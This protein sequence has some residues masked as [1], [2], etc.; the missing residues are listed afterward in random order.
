MAK[1]TSIIP[2]TGRLG[3]MIGYYRD[4]NYYLRSMPKKVRQTTHTRRAAKRFGIASKRGALIRKAIYGE[5]DIPCDSNHVTRLTAALITASTNNLQAIQDFRF[6]QPA[7][8]SRFFAIA[9]VFTEDGQ[10]HIPAQTLP[11]FKGIRYWEVKVIA[12][13]IDFK[14]HKAIDTDVDG[15]TIDPRHTFTGASLSVSVPG[16]GTLVVVLQVRAFSEQ[17][18]SQNKQNMAAD[19]IA[20]QEAH[21]PVKQPASVRKVTVPAAR[22]K[23][24]RPGQQSTP[25]HRVQRE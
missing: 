8:I 6:N 21:M 9:P 20:I 24:S 3:N 25:Q 12:T 7:G 15:I 23:V 4:G 2:F 18:P 22:Q 17:H 10:L 13:R 19:I 5:L 1:Q 14:K 16:S 11:K